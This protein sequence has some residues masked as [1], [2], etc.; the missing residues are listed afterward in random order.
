MIQI[1]QEIWNT[2]ATWGTLKTP[3]MKRLC[4]MKE[5]EIDEFLNQEYQKLLNQGCNEMAAGIFQEFR[6]QILEPETV[7]KI[8]EEFP[9]IEQALP[10][11]Q[12]E[13]EALMIQEQEHRWELTDDER[14][15]ILRDLKKL[16]ASQGGHPAP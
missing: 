10:M 1:P 13:K 3:I 4:S 7:K 14:N 9:G 11:I 8:I 2:A 15:T 6:P 16:I 5:G 12:D